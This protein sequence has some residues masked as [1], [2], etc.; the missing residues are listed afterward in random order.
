MINQHHNIKFPIKD[1]NSVPYDSLYIILFC[2]PCSRL[3]LSTIAAL[4]RH[5]VARVRYFSCRWSGLFCL[6]DQSSWEC[7][8][9]CGT[10]HPIK[11]VISEDPLTL[12]YCRA[13][14]SWLF[15]RL[16]S[17]KAEFKHPTFRQACALTNCSTVANDL[18]Y[19]S[20][21]K[22]TNTFLKIF[23]KRNRN[24]KC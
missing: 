22:E 4:W 14:R 21:L 10:G 15:L 17:V 1:I 16:R 5:P 20:F 2:V 7:H 6:F 3:S 9:Y 8:T 18:V 24:K 12:T 19:L 13:F 11:M 23:S